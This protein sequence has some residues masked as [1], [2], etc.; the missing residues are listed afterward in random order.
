MKQFISNKVDKI[1]SSQIQKA[2]KLAATLKNPID[3]SIGIPFG[4]TPTPVK[5]ASIKAINDNFTRY[6]PPQGIDKLIIRLFEKLKNK[7]KLPIKNKDCII[8]TPGVTVGLLLVFLVLFEKDNE[9]IFFDPFFP[10]Y[11]QLCNILGIKPKL[12]STYPNFEL[13]SAKLEKAINKK[14]KAILINSP[15]NPTGVV[16]SK[17]NL[18]EI[19][20]LA[21]KHNLIV[22]SDEIYEDFTYTGAHFSIGSVYKNTITLNGFSK[23]F[24]MSGF[25]I[26]YLAGPDEI[27]DA[28]KKIAPYTYFSNSSIAQYAALEALETGNSTIIKEHK[29]RRDLAIKLLSPKFEVHGGDGAFYL[30]LRAPNSDGDKFVER[31]AQKNLLLLPGSLFSTENTHFRLSYATPIENLKKGAEIINKLV[32]PL[33]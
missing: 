20:R 14:T 10:V 6:T 16:Y 28:I 33:V 5:R 18:S 7:N 3:L 25:R 22:I 26:G 27:I 17:D 2:Y 13:D 8:V 1:D 31:A 11:L 32:F 29:K 21:K 24:A 23:S 4:N 12:I 9:I 30:F 19:T 15:N